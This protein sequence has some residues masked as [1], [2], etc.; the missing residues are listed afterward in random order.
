M[1]ITNIEKETIDNNNYRK[2]ISTNKNTQLVLMSLKPKEEIGLEMH[3]NLDQFF[4]VEK[5]KGKVLYGDTKDSLTEKDLED[6]TAFIIPIG[7]WHNIIN[8]SDKEALKLYTIYAPPNHPADRIQENNPID[9]DGGSKKYYN[10]YMKYK[11]KYI[12]SKKN[13]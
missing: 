13:K 9:M 1:F 3:D 11:T 8:V 12:K 4:C 10:K 6:G 5:G 7:T 2:V